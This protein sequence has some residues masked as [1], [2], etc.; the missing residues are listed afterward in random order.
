MGVIYTLEKEIIINQYQ[1][2]LKFRSIRENFECPDHDMTGSIVG[3]RFF[4]S[5]FAIAKRKTEKI[6]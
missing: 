1:K 4:C 6:N 5:G 2:M 3:L